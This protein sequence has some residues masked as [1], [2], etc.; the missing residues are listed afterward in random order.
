MMSMHDIRWQQR[1]DNFDR[2]FVLLR[3]VQERGMDS[4]SQLEREVSPKG[5]T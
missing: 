2:A 1:F 3:E 5:T 4:L